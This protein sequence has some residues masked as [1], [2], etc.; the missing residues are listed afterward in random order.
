[1]A[2]ETII[3]DGDGAPGIGERLV[4]V[5]KQAGLYTADVV[6][7]SVHRHFAIQK[8][9]VGFTRIKGMD[10]MLETQE[11]VVTGVSGAATNLVRGVLS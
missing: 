7:K 8:K 4:G 11:A 2:D 1:M 9:L 5:A 3:I 6:D 10:T